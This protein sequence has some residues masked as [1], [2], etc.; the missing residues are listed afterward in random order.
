MANENLKRVVIS[1]TRK[2][3]KIVAQQVVYKEKGFS[4]TTHEDV[5]EY[6]KGLVS[7]L[8][9]KSGRTLRKNKS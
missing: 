7:I 5:F 4:T 3:G 2:D 8:G 1:S 6:S 9:K